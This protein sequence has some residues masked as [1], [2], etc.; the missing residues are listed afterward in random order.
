MPQSLHTLPLCSGGPLSVRGWG[1]LHPLPSL[2]EPHP[3]HMA[4]PGSGVRRQSSSGPS[5]LTPGQV[6]LDGSG[7]TTSTAN[8]DQVSSQP[9]MGTRYE[10]AGETFPLPK[11]CLYFTHEQREPHHPEDVQTY[12]LMRILSATTTPT[13]TFGPH[14]NS[15]HP[16]S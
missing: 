13:E 11:L 7:P 16:Y 1:T 4:T 15:S 14:Q 9:G 3:P 12:L 6:T 10:Q 8:R 2:P 5:S